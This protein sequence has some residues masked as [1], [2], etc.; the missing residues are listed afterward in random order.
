[1]QFTKD[2]LN[3]DSVTPMDDTTTQNPDEEKLLPHLIQSY[4]EELCEIAAGYNDQK[5][6]SQEQYEVDR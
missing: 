5:Q 3:T 2:Q 1:M 4:I 6:I